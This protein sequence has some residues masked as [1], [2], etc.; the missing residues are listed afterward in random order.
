MPYENGTYVQPSRTVR[1][2]VKEWVSDE[3]DPAFDFQKIA[4]ECIKGMSPKQSIEK[5]VAKWQAYL[6]KAAQPNAI[7]T[8]DG[9]WPRCGWKP[10]L[11]VG[12]ASQ[13]P[14]WTP[15]PVVACTGTFGVEWMDFN[16]IS[17][18]EVKS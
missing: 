3:I 6:A 10:V 13:W 4:A 5:V 16:S 17:G 2:L 7:V 11:K 1:E 14:Y 12:M 8:D 15:R 9:G 18:V